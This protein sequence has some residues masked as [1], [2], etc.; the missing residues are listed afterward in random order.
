MSAETRILNQPVCPGQPVG[1]ASSTTS[2]SGTYV[3]N[4]TVFAS[5]SGYLS[6]RTILTPDGSRTAKTELF[7]SRSPLPASTSLTFKST[8]PDPAVSGKSLPEVGAVVYATVT[9]LQQDRANVEILALPSST[10]STFQNSALL[11]D[12]PLASGVGVSFPGV[13]RREDIRATEKDRVK[14]LDSFRPGDIVRAVV[15]S[16]G[17]SGAYSLSTARN[18]LGV[19]LA[20][21]SGRSVDGKNASEGEV[22]VPVSWEFFETENG[23]RERRKVAKPL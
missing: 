13:I 17:D 5:Q 6:L 4:G 10:A 2:G 18:D 15:L 21:T 9:R 3:Y 19:L 1:S 20:R 7:V 8:D 23:V 14:V 12:S 11:S 22:M 16:L